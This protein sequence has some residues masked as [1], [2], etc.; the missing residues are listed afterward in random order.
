MN[1]VQGG[2]WDYCMCE[3]GIKMT[4]RRES[5]SEW[6]PMAQRGSRKHCQKMY[7]RSKNLHMYMR[8]QSSLSLLQWT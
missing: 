5:S 2:G 7:G 8:V 1:Q 4:G 6:K 3:I